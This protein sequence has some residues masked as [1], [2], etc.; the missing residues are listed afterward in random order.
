MVGLPWKRDDP[1][2]DLNFRP[3]MGCL[4]T[5]LNKLRRTPELL[6]QYNQIMVDQVNAGILEPAPYVDHSDP[7]DKLYYM[8]H[9]P[10]VKETSIT[11]KKRIVYDCSSVTRR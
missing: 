1:N 4:K 2:P 9:Q 6:E 5:T 8:P 11:T 3:S 7:P 10:V